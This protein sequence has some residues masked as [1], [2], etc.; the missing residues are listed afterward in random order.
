MIIYE[1]KD[2]EEAK[3]VAEND[4]IIKRNLYSYELFEW[5]LAILSDSTK[6]NT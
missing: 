1:A 3:E 5:E 2:L 4:P 6:K